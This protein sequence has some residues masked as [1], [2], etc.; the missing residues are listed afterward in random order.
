MLMAVNL[1]RILRALPSYLAEVFVRSKLVLGGGGTLIVALA[2]Y[3]SVAPKPLPPS[4]C[5][6]VFLAAIICAEIAHGLRSFERMHPPFR[7]IHPKLQFWNET[8][9]RGSTGTGYYFEVHNPSKTE[10]LE[11]V[12]AQLI[13]IDPKSIVNLPI[14]LHIRHKLY[15]TS[16]TQITIPPDGIAGFDIVTGPDHNEHSQSFVLVPCVVGGDRGITNS[17]QIPKCRHRLVIRVTS[18]SYVSYLECEVWV[19][20][21]FLRCEPRDTYIMEEK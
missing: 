7:A 15:A 18:K 10:S 8:S 21:N 12:G 14:P 6:I 13:S 1:K 16:E 17:F 5:V 4:T 2:I 20:D 9:H 19:E 3:Q 11:S